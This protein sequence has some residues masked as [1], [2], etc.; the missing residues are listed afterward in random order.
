METKPELQT[1]FDTV[2]NID[3]Y[4][5]IRCRKGFPAADN[6][7]RPGRAAS[8][9]VSGFSGLPATWTYR[10]SP[11]KTL[12][13]RNYTSMMKSL[14]VSMGSIG[15]PEMIV[16]FLVALLVFGP[17]RL[18]D[19]GRSIG[20]GLSEFRR[21]SNDLKGSIEREIETLDHEVS[22]ANIPKTPDAGADTNAPKF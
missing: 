9:T 15:F 16:I 12:T 18:P 20:R 11:L 3:A 17:K 2:K 19:L 7:N 8:F 6:G 1:T 13:F 21:A 22:S 5:C 10:S 4:R 14:G